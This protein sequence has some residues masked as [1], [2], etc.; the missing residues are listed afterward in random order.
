MAKK[1]KQT[2]KFSKKSNQVLIYGNQYT[3]DETIRKVR[4]Q[5]VA[6]EVIRLDGE[7]LSLEQFSR[8][9]CF[10]DMFDSSK[11]ILVRN[12][13]K[14]KADKLIEVF[15]KVPDSVFVVVYSYSSQKA[16]KKLCKYFD[17]YAKLIEYE[18]QV[19]NIDKIITRIAKEKGKTVADDSLHLMQQYLGTHLGIVQSEVEKLCNYIGDRKEIQQKDVESVCCLTREF[20]IWDFLRHAGAKDVSQAMRSLSSAAESGFTYEFLILMLMRSLR[21]SIFLKELDGEGMSIWEITQKIKEYKKTNGSFVYRDYEIKKT[22]E[23]RNNFFTNFSLMELCHSLRCCH[24]AFLNVR[25]AYK[26]EEQEKE[27]SLLLFAVCFPS[28]FMDK[29]K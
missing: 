12:F 11:L 22:Y 9:I 13:P 24:E 4:D 21:L 23:A 25:K 1:K 29:G 19:K 14:E 20:V 6:D 28:S 15:Q 8:E 7:S 5:V 27:V 26:K 18:V 17:T 2:K 16:K 3:V 10:E